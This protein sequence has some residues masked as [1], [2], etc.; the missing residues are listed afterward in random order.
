MAVPSAHSAQCPRGGGWREAGPAGDLGWGQAIARRLL[1]GWT[2]VGGLGPT[3]QGPG[4]FSQ[5]E[6][7]QLGAE[8]VGEAWLQTALPEVPCTKRRLINTVE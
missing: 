7:E 1:D 4:S 2:L 5:A 6:L 3:S 8:R